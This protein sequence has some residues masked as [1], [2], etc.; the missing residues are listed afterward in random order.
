MQYLHYLIY[1]IPVAI[2]L[3]GYVGLVVATNEP[4]PF[5][6]VL[7]PSMQPTILPGSVAVIDKVPFDQ[8][9]VG[10]VIVFVPQIAL[11]Y[12]CDSGPTNSLITET[13]VPCFVIH[14]IVN[15]TTD[16][17]GNRI[18]TTK[19]DNNAFSL[20]VPPIDVGINE[21]MY[22]GKVIMQFPVAGYITTSPTNEIIALLILGAFAGDLLYERSTTQRVKK[23]SPVDTTKKEEHTVQDEEMQEEEEQHATASEFS[24][25]SFPES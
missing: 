25:R 9:K 6:I 21:S 24:T 22:I 18:I 13:S 1:L 14:R 20:R 11:I 17:N 5:T 23:S 8:L 16:Q 4:S 15:I 19:G 10:D 3:L 2:L 12:H 7:G